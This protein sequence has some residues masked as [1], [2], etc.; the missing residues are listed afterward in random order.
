MAGRK[1]RRIV[2]RGI[3][4]TSIKLRRC[5]KIS[6]AIPVVAA[7]QDKAIDRGVSG[8]TVREINAVMG[9]LTPLGWP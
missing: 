6:M 1:R 2:F 7:E 5:K 9:E 8:Y 4:A 3:L